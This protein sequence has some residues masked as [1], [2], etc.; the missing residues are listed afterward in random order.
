MLTL[1][2]L[3]DVNVIEDDGGVS[4]DVGC[5]VVFPIEDEDWI[6]EG[7]RIVRV[8]SL[9]HPLVQGWTIF[10]DL[11]NSELSQAERVLRLFHDDRRAFCLID[12]NCDRINVRC[13]STCF[14]CL[15]DVVVQF[16]A[17]SE[18]WGRYDQSKYGA[19]SFQCC[20][21]LPPL[22]AACRTCWV[23]WSG[24]TQLELELPCTLS[25]NRRIHESWVQCM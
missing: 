10:H 2:S 14:K 13:R 7:F 24:S 23:P 16:L 21:N 15:P 8:R 20:T 4:A 6:E 22:R 1:P 18:D 12:K 5:R 3:F 25:S 17:L 9:Q 11:H 19:D